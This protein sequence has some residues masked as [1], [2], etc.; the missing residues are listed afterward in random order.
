MKKIGIVSSGSSKT[1]AQIILNEGMEK[2]VKVED[3]ILIDNRASNKILKTA[4]PY[5]RCSSSAPPFCFETLIGVDVKPILAYFQANHNPATGL[6]F[7]LD[8]V[9][10]NVTLPEGFT[11]EFVKEVESLLIKDPK[12]DKYDLSN[13]F[14]SINPQKEE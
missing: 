2:E 1:D 4:R 7:P 12:L 8:L 3:L 6:P 11:K 10:E 9:D 13:H 14:L 5:V